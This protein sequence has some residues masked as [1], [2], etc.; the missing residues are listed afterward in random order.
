MNCPKCRIGKVEEVTLSGLV[1]EGGVDSL[2][3]DRCFGC[4]G[5]WFD[6]GELDSAIREWVIDDLQQSFSVISRDP[7]A[8]AEVDATPMECPRCG[9]VLTK[10]KARKQD[11]VIDECGK[12][13]GVWVDGHELGKFDS[14]EEHLQTV[15]EEHTEHPN[16]FIRTFAQVAL[17][18]RKKKG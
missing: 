16:F 10:K 6:T 9:V 7:K 4:G 11:V 12:C 3:V 18:F 13:A 1:V 8:H 5:V 2:T 17:R 15:L 14:G